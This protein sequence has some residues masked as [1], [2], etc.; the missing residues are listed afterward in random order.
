M[1]AYSEKYLHRLYINLKINY[2]SY[3]PLFLEPFSGG[4]RKTLFSVEEDPQ[5][6]E[7][8]KEMALEA[9]SSRQYTDVDRFTLRC[10]QCDI[11]LKGQKEASLHANQFPGHTNFGEV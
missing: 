1:M 5:I 2:S 9:K 11:Q 4:A 6:F 7:M 10:L 8:A 3:D